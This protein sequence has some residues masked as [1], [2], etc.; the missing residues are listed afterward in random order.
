MIEICDFLET[1]A[2]FL[3]EMITSS[4]TNNPEQL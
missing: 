3:L 4:K 1:L 2:K